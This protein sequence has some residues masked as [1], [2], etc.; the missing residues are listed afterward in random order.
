MELYLIRH[1]QSVNNALMEDQILRVADPELTPVGHQ[2]AQHIA[3]YLATALHRDRLVTFR[4]EEPER[5]QQ[6]PYGITHLYA[7]AMTRAMQ[8]CQPIAAALGLQPHI[9]LDIHEHGG[10]YL[11]KDGVVTGYGGRTRSQI[12]ADFPTY[13]IPDAITEQGWWQMQNAYEDLPACQARATRVAHQ[14]RRR[15][16]VEA[17]THDRVAL[18]THGTF[19]DSLLKAL[20]NNLPS[21]DYYINHWNTG[22]TQIDITPNDEMRVRY[23]NRIDHLTNDLVTA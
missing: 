23:I 4:P 5:Q 18:V 19:M 14:L 3:T 2:Q 13:M 9:W 10:I 6:H 16:E 1:G 15:A 12:S 11:E 7:S 8:T 20:F 21:P 22:I 17:T